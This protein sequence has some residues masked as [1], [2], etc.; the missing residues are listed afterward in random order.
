M[1]FF[2]KYRTSSI[3]GWFLALFAFNLTWAW[4][5]NADRTSLFMT[6][7]A[8]GR[9]T[10]LPELALSATAMYWIRSERPPIS[11][12]RL[13]AYIVV[14]LAAAVVTFALSYPEQVRSAPAKILRSLSGIAIAKNQPLSSVE[15]FQKL[16]PSVYVVESLGQNG[17][18]LML[19]SAVAVDRNFLIT[20]CH[21][22]HSGSFLRIKRGAGKWSATLVKRYRGTIFVDSLS[23]LDSLDRGTRLRSL[24]RTG[25]TLYYPTSRF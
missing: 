5:Q 16:S 15:L 11:T 1:S 23:V 14:G 12:T 13:L 25:R 3:V 24:D 8:I 6:L 10:T 9:L 18:T 17:E 4:L 7:T 21:V 22:V 20:N 2:K 19:G